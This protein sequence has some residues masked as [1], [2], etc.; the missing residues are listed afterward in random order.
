[1]SQALWATR[2]A[3]AGQVL[4]EAPHAE[5][6]LSF[7]VRLT[8]LQESVA[9]S[10]PVDRIIKAV[11]AV[12]ANEPVLSPRRLPVDELLLLFEEFLQGVLY[13]GTEEI[14]AGARALL[15]TGPSHA[16]AALYTAE[17]FHARA[18]L[19]SVMITL[20]AN[21]SEPNIG[22]NPKHCYVCGS[23][24]VV[25]FLQDLPDTLGKRSLACSLCSTEW[26]IDRLRCVNCGETN[27]DQ[28]LV[29]N[30]ESIPHVRLEECRTC[31]RYLKTVALLDRG[32]AVPV[33][34]ELAT[35]EMDLWARDKGLEKL[36]LNILEL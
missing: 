20:A 23:R 32:D 6:L 2:R 24:P 5:E 17:G 26:R 34:D 4:R 1:M 7:Y 16:G 22:K 18:F 14:E 19:E 36:Q 28:L 11:P 3:R 13:T 27:A 21:T 15:H 25:S 30:A 12:K 35:I 31:R 10:L 9:E 29:H 8:E 33:V